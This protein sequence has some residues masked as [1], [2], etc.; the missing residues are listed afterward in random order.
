MLTA[1]VMVCSLVTEG[2]CM[3]FT[4]NRGPYKTEAECLVRVEEMISSMSSL[5][6]PVPS[7]IMYKCEDITKGVR[8]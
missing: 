8:T 2:D 1:I 5:L 6:P 7:Q 4:D 3:K